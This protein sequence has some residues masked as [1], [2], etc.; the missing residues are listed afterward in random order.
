MTTYAG[1]ILAVAILSWMASWLA[2]RFG[3]ICSR[4]TGL[5]VAAYAGTAAWVA[6]GFALLPLLAPLRILGLYSLYLLHMGLRSLTGV[7]EEPRRR[8]HCRGGG[9]DRPP[10]RSSVRHHLDRPSLARPA[11]RSTFGSPP[12]K[13]EVARTT[14]RRGG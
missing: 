5:K 4:G 2:P 10:A 11:C 14:S 6:G 3:A 1:S 12:P 8:I 13:A 9:R 7:T